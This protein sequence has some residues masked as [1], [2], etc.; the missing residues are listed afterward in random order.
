MPHQTPARYAASATV[1]DGISGGQLRPDKKGAIRMILRALQAK[2]VTCVTC[3]L[4][5]CLL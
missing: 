5:V 2:P 3:V 4:F 1:K